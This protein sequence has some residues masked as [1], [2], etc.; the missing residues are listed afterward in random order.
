MQ[1][2]TE[3]KKTVNECIGGKIAD[4][5]IDSILYPQLLMNAYKIC[6]KIY[7]MTQTSLMF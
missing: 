1:I 7:K 2:L 4:N 6:I 3:D 5:W